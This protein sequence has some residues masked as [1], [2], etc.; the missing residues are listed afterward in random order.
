[1]LTPK[2]IY[3][4]NILRSRIS[5]SIDKSPSS[6]TRRILSKLFKSIIASVVESEQKK[7]EFYNSDG[8]SSFNYFEHLKGKFNDSLSKDDVRNKLKRYF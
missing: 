6:G 4:A 2:K 5:N 8:F 1:M 3:Y 7:T